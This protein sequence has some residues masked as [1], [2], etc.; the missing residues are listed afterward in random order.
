MLNDAGFSCVVFLQHE[1][2]E[3]TKK[4]SCIFEKTDERQRLSHKNE[5][6]LPD[7]SLRKL[8]DEGQSRMAA[9]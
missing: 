2:I 5:T 3:E 9:R 6:G 7:F 8:L 1:I 4:F